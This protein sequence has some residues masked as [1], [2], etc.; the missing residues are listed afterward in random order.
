MSFLERNDGDVEHN[1]FSFK[2]LNEVYGDPDGMLTQADGKSLV[3]IQK[4]EADWAQ[5][6]VKSIS[7]YQITTVRLSQSAEAGE[8]NLQFTRLNLGTIIS[9]GEK[10]HAMVGD[11]REEFFGEKGLGHHSFL[12]GTAIPTRRYA[13]EQVAA[14]IVAQ[15]FSL[16]NDL[17]YAR[18]RHFDLQKL[19][20]EHATLDSQ[21][22]ERLQSVREVLDLLSA[23]F[24]DQRI[25]R[26]RAMTVSTVLLAR[27]AGV[28]SAEDARDLAEFV[29][30]LQ[31]RGR[32]QA[33]KGFRAD[34]EY[35]E[36]LELQRHIT[37][38]SAEKPAVKRRAEIMK[39]QFDRWRPNKIFDG[40]KEWKAKN[41]G[42]EPGEECRS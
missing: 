2:A 11:L 24:G 4:I 22:R 26:N 42:R 30:G 8:F 20:K 33:K 9:S 37:Q 3:Q 7:D 36:L 25:L 10:L 5:K 21:A 39:A 14:Q 31:C 35:S 28:T 15:V 41:E 19:F 23:G 32:W 6:F 1:G 40:D 16:S 12:A 18:T 29:D 13:Q 38:A 34:P 27:E 17:G